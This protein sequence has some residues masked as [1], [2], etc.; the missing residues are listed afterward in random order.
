MYNEI[1]GSYTQLITRFKDE[2][3]RRVKWESDNW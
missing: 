3:K 1:A 2:E